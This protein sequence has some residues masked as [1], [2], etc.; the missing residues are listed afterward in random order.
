MALFDRPFAAVDMPDVHDNL[1]PRLLS[2]G[3]VEG[4]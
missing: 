2:P 4:D 3:H 1:P